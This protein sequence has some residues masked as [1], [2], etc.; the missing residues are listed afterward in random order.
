MADYIQPVANGIRTDH[1]YPNLPFVEDAHIPIDDPKGIESIGRIPEGSTW[2]RQDDDA[3]SGE[4]V[5]FTTSG[6][7]TNSRLPSSSA[8]EGPCAVVGDEL[9]RMLAPSAPDRARLRRPRPSPDRICSSR[10][11]DPVGEG[12]DPRCVVSR[13]P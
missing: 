10:T 1:P 9:S 5:A 3:R 7:A 8:C 2:G 12:P 11:V 4:W 13:W 6:A